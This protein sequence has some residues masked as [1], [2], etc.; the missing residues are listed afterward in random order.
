MGTSSGK[1]GVKW[2]PYFVQQ[3]VCRREDFRQGGKALGTTTSD[4]LPCR[5]ASL[6]QR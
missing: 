1:N 3:G 6:P 5:Q 2:R 4:F